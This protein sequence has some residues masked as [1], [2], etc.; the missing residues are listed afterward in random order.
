MPGGGAFS[1]GVRSYPHGAIA[2]CIFL[3]AEARRAPL[4]A[5]PISICSPRRA[6]SSV[7]RRTLTPESIVP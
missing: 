4:R 3:L 2:G 5:R 1:F 6:G 7:R